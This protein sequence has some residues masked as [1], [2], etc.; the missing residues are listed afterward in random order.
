MSI[1]INRPIEEVFAVLAD[2]ENDIKWRSE[3]VETQNLSEEPVG[4]G[5]TFRLTGVFLCRRIPTTYELIE[6][7]PNQIVAWKTVSGPLPLKFQRSFER[8][9]GGTRSSINYFIEARGFFRLILSLLGG[10]VKRQHQGDLR[11]LKELLET[12]A[13]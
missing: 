4:I 5:S 6:F 9:E 13:L 7:K 11:K 1:V 10:M 12:H 8:A 3:W 2:L